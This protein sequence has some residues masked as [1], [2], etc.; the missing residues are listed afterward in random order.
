M[1]FQHSLCLWI[2]RLCICS[3]APYDRCLCPVKLIPSLPTSLHPHSVQFAVSVIGKFREHL[4]SVFWISSVFAPY[5]SDLWCVPALWK[6]T[7]KKK[8]SKNCASSPN[9]L[10]WER[11]GRIIFPGVFSWL[12]ECVVSLSGKNWSLVWS[13]AGPFCPTE[14]SHAS[15]MEVRGHQ[16]ITIHR[17]LFWLS[18]LGSVDLVWDFSSFSDVATAFFPVSGSSGTLTYCVSRWCR[19]SKGWSGSLIW[20]SCQRCS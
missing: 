10:R 9:V 4:T 16:I 11:E 19:F 20:Q 2:K 14:L 5:A 13:W 3:Q 7:I 12:W 17:V 6:R 15:G 18:C 1:N 8:K